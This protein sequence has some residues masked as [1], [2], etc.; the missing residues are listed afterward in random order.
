MKSNLVCQN[1]ETVRINEHFQ[2]PKQLSPDQVEQFW[3]DGFLFPVD[4]FDGLQARKYRNL[5]EE[6]ERD[7]PGEIHAEHR[8]NA[9]YIL[10]FLDEIAHHPVI[11]D[12]MEDLLGPDVLLTGTVL[13]IKE[14]QTPAFVSWHQDSTYTGIDPKEGIT[15]WVALSEAS[16]ES[17]CM[18]MI[19]ESHHQ[20]ILEHHDRFGEDNILTRGQTIEGI[21]KERAV[22]VTLKPGQISLH[23]VRTVHSSTPN[24]S[25][26]RRI[27][28]ALQSF[29]AASVKQTLGEDYALS[30]RGQD[31]FQHFLRARRPQ[32]DYEPEGI[33]FREAAN[34]RLS[35]ILYHGSELKRDY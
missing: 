17:G 34:Q 35:D 18:Q 3:N 33:A 26:D 22:D 8:N 27:G 23:H 20:G 5:L 32:S 31:P 1:R 19:P 9:H 10:K 25:D 6:A 13:F 29:I 14:P 28:L 12:V 24:R 2:M 21:E 7:H 30:V 16:S 4:A 11:L 15:V